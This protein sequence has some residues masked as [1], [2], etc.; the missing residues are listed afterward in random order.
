M[1]DAIF[2]PLAS[3]PYRHRK[4]SPFS[5]KWASTLDLLE[6]ELKTL[7]ANNIVIQAGFRLEQIRN[8]GWPRSGEKPSHPGVVLS[9]NDRKGSPLSFPCD[10]Y[11]GH[12]QNIRAIALSLQAL[13]AVNRYGVVKTDEQYRGFAALPEAPRKM[14]KEDALA[15]FAL[16]GG[17]G[18][19]NHSTF[20]GAYRFA[21]AKL[22]PDNQSTGSDHLFKM[23]GEAKGILMDAYGWPA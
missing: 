14:T 22:H 9:F 6:S 13:R 15:F 20:K 17:N 11:T 21:A 3:P 4:A 10:T 7:G 2:R 1:I 23:L 18:T 19:V 5:S 12:E 16:H 8:D